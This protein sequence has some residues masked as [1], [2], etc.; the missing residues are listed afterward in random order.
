LSLSFARAGNAINSL[1]ILGGGW[2]GLPLA[3]LP[4]DA[5]GSYPGS[6][7]TIVLFCFEYKKP[8]LERAGQSSGFPV[9][10]SSFNQ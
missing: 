5:C 4:G 1:S 9:T 8:A 7:I 3:A 6:G 10:G 2:L